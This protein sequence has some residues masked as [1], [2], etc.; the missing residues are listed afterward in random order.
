MG[1]KKMLKM[2][3]KELQSNKKILFAYLFGSFATYP[4]YARDIDIAVFVNGRI[5]RNFERKLSSSLSK[6]VK[7]DIDVFVLN[8]MPLLFLSEVFRTGV[9]LFSR[10]ERKRIEFETKKLTEVQEFNDLIEYYNLMRCKRY[11]AG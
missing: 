2:L 5:S 7:K 6:K 9:L 3:R 11:E 1:Y 8:E 4:N 10:N